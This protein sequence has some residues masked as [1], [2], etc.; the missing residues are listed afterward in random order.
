MKLNIP[1]NYKNVLKKLTDMGFQ[2]Y[3]VGGCVRDLLL[4]ITPDDYDVTTSATPQQIKKV[5]QKTIDT[6]IKY[7]TVTVIEGDAV[8]EVTTFRSET[9]YSDMRRPDSVEFVSDIK[10]DLSRRDFTI[11]AIC[12]NPDT[13]IIDCFNSQN[14]LHNGILRTVGNAEERFKED[15][16]R[17]VRLFRFSSTLDFE[18]AD[19]TY[20]AAVKHSPLIKNISRERIATE[21]SKAACGK[22]VESFNSLIGCGALNFCGIENANIQNI[23]L[24]NGSQNLR[25]YDFLKATSKEISIPLKELKM[26]NAFKKYCVD[27]EYLSANMKTLTVVEIKTLMRKVD[28]SIIADYVEFKKIVDETDISEAF[29]TANKIISANEPYKISHLNICGND[30]SSLGFTG[31]QI[32]SI[33]EFLIEKVI[34]DK[35][36][37]TK[38]ALIKIAKEKRN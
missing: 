17:I 36:L 19:E 37:N 9:T 11:N 23:S 4:G 27:M 16:L 31:K 6:G 8:C 18:I 1:E 7:G 2:A 26:N 3:I 15:P 21:I 22:N 29:K 32:G 24:L 34:Y 35:T 33:L 28:I 30:L 14:D 38:E 20:C 25:L 10:S 5:F 12:Y 13:G